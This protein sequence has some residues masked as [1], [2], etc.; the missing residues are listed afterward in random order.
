MGNRTLSEKGPEVNREVELLDVEHL[1]DVPAFNSEAELAEYWSTHGPTE[2]FLDEAEIQRPDWLPVA[3]RI[4]PVAIRFDADA[5]CRLKALAKKK[6]KGYQT[7]LK[8]FVMERLYEEEKR[9]G[10]IPVAGQR[11]RRRSAKARD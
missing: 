3:P 2:Q 5:L 4:N 7:L 6:H 8:E 9:E 10:I 11:T 1:A